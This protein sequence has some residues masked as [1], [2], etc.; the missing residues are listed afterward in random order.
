MSQSE[1]DDEPQPGTGE[2]PPTNITPVPRLALDIAA[3]LKLFEGATPIQEIVRPVRGATCV[4]YGRGDASGEG[5]GS[6][7]T[8]LGMPPLVRKGF[9][10]TAESEESSNHREFK[11]LLETVREES[12]RGRLTGKEPWLATDN[13]TAEAAC[14]KGR[15]SSKLLDGMVLELRE[16]ATKC[17]FV[18]RMVHIAGTRMIET[19]IDGLSRGELHLGALA[20]AKGSALLPLHLDPTQRSGSL[21]LW[22]RSWAGTDVNFASPKDW[23]HKAQQGGEHDYPQVSKTWVWALPPAAALCALE[24]LGNGRL[25]RHNCLRGIVLVPGLLRPEWFRR[26]RRVV[27]FYFFAPAGAIDAWPKSMHEP[28][29][30]GVYLPLLRHDPWDWRRV[31]FLVPFGISLSALYKKGDS[32]GGNLLREFWEASNWIAHVP[33]RLVRDLLSHSSWRRFLNMSRDRRG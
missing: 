13:S 22:L 3:L 24:E 6:Q 26:F 28:L 5:F 32:S 10:C 25:K 1:T 15:S 14:F 16:M 7:T 2:D 33:E 27:D 17:N 31:P 9:W 4:L 29:T 20:L 11:N 21:K 23:F 30:I 8:P 19:G 18:L 12:Q